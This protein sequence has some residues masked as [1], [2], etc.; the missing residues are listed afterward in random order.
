[1]DLS[2]ISVNGIPLKDDLKE[3]LVPEVL[4]LI[5]EQVRHRAVSR[6]VRY[7][8]K[9]EK[10]GPV[11]HYTGED[12]KIFEAIDQMLETQS[13][14]TADEIRLKFPAFNPRSVTMALARHPGLVR[15][16]RGV[17]TKEGEE[18]K[19]AV[20]AVEPIKIN[21]DVTITIKFGG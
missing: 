11:I 8:S 17:Y 20:A 1:M 6:K 4:K 16:R 7:I 19:E 21:V 12:M 9:A 18:V 3:R 13:K 2:G 14:I 5:N 10:N 15:I